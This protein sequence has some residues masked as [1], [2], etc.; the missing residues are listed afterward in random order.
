MK[1]SL[2]HIQRMEKAQR[3]NARAIR[4][5]EWRQRIG[6]DI[7]ET[8]N[9]AWYGFWKPIIFVWFKWGGVAFSVAFGV[10]LAGI[11]IRGIINR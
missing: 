3:A 8:L 1:Y 10:W 4:R 11:V 6:M 9:R 7:H 5:M 2:Q